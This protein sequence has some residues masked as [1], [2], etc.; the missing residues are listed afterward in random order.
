MKN[1]KTSALSALTMS[2]MAIPGMGTQQAKADVAPENS[3]FSY[4]YTNYQES[5]APKERVFSGSIDRYNIQVHQF[6]LLAPIKEKYSIKTDLVFESLSGASPIRNEK[7]DDGSTRMY[8]SG[9]SIDEQRIDLLVAPKR[10]FESGNLGGMLSISQENDYESTALGLDGALEIFNKHTTLNGSLS[11]SRDELSP[12]GGGPADGKTKDSF[13]F[14]EGLSQVI[15]KYRVFQAGFGYTRHSGY[16][17][18]PYKGFDL[19]PEERNQYTL[20]TAYRH[21][22]N[23]PMLGAGSWHLDYRYYEDSWKIRSHTIST[24]WWKDTTILGQSFTL[25]P[26]LRYYMQNSAYFYTLDS[27]PTDEFYSSDARLSS[28]GALT[29]GFDAKWKTQ[30]ATYTFGFAQ[31]LS[32]EDWN[33]LEG[34]SDETPGLVDFTTVSLGVDYPFSF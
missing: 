28:F 10:H 21:Y 33:L 29:F 15:D 18:D 4:R 13:S 27:N 5:Q 3:V 31:Y 11:W 9:A 8:M 26:S 12:T 7:L 23:T 14:Y 32:S 24:S 16:L 22:L 19:R 20:T 6:S 34:E 17:T 2:A 1:K 30:K 25:A